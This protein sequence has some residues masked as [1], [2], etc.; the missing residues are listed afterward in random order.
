MAKRSI[1]RSIRQAFGGVSSK[2]AAIV[3][4]VVIGATGLVAL[5]YVLI[6]NLTGQT[7]VDTY[8]KQYVTVV[9]DYLDELD[10]YVK[11]NGTGGL[12]PAQQTALDDK[13]NLLKTIQGAAAQAAAQGQM[14]WQRFI[15]Y[16][17]IAIGGVI[18]LKFGPAAVSAFLNAVKGGGTPKTPQSYVQVFQGS[19]AVS[20][21]AVGDLALATA[22]YNTTML[23]DS[24]SLLLQLQLEQAAL[25]AQ[26]PSLTG[27]ALETALLELSAIQADIAFE[28]I[29]ASYVPPLL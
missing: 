25:S 20:L 7:T 6:Q 16:L 13:V 9:K 2:D 17:F 22:F 26:I 11:Q 10:M 19:E 5:G 28:P 12:T 21:A 23:S 29:I 8:T 1:G 24:L 4:G 15:D 27:L 3:G 18:L 14:P